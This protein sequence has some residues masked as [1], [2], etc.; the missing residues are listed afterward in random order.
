MNSDI[1]IAIVGFSTLETLGL[2]FLFRHDGVAAECFRSLE[3]CSDDAERF[4]G[5]VADAGSFAL[6]T[7]FFLPRKAKLLVV[8]GGHAVALSAQPLFIGTDADDS[9]LQA[10]ADRFVESLRSNPSSP[11]EEISQREREVIREI[12]AGKTNKEIADTLCISV[13]TVI[14]HRKNI[15][16]KLGIKSASAISLYAMMHGM[17]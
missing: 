2:R 12:A 14:T 8:T 5:F 16:S 10:C 1:S 11:A 7:D 17:I 3:S 6:H 13:N 9:D 4:D 15:A